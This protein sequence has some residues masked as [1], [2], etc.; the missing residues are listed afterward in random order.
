MT[1]LLCPFFRGKPN[2]PGHSTRTQFGG[3]AGS[4]GVCLSRILCNLCDRFGVYIYQGVISGSSARRG[5]IVRDGDGERGRG[6][7]RRRLQIPLQQACN[8]LATSLQ[9]RR[10]S[11][12]ALVARACCYRV[13]V[14]GIGRAGCEA[15]LRRQH[16]VVAF[17][18]AQ[19]QVFAEEEVFRGDG[20][21]EA[22]LADII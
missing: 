14:S 7:Q 5:G 18:F 11:S 13:S 20:A 12:A 9:L 21:L 19:E 16:H 3:P 15:S 8:M 22:R 6:G 4:M 1:Q 2:T 10:D 17:A